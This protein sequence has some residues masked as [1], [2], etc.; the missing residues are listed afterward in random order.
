[1]I[2][3]SKPDRSSISL[4]PAGQL[5]L[6]G[7][8]LETI[9][10]T[11][12]EV[13]QH[14]KQVKEVAGELGIGFLGLGYNPKWPREDMPWMP[15]G[16]YKIMRAYMPTKGNFGH[17]MMLRTCTVQVNLDFDSEADM[18]KKM[19]VGVALQPIATA[20]FAASHERLAAI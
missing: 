19:R 3:L 6:S 15:K 5:E 7:A 12:G 16:R 17:D 18:V 2:A 13:T 20:L 10:Q 4:E 14:L 9:H 8:P 1:M 11:C